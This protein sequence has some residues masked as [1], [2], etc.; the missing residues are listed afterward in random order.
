MKKFR[1]S[2]DCGEIGI[3]N[4]R[5][6]LFVLCVTSLLSIAGC[7]NPLSKEDSPS[8]MEVNDLFYFQFYFA[9]DLQIKEGYNVTLETVSISP[10]DDEKPFIG[11]V[12]QEQNGNPYIFDVPAG[13]SSSDGIWFDDS[14]FESPVFYFFDTQALESGVVFTEQGIAFSITTQHNLNETKANDMNITDVNEDGK[15]QMCFIG[16]NEELSS[17]HALYVDQGNSNLSE[18]EALNLL[19]QRYD[20]YLDLFEERGVLDVYKHHC[21]ADHSLG[22]FTLDF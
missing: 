11:C 10:C 6:I 4:L 1:P 17:H 7:V 3:H 14:T 15:L 22:S 12:D 8:G 18:E 21:E 16:L 13:A 20:S 2:V 19:T 9:M 5:T